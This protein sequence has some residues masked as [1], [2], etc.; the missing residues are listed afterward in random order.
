MSGGDFMN[1]SKWIMGGLVVVST[2]AV[3]LPAFAAE[4]GESG[5]SSEGTAKPKSGAKTKGGADVKFDTLKGDTCKSNFDRIEKPL[6]K[7]ISAASKG[8]EKACA[9]PNKSKKKDVGT[10]LCSVFSKDGKI[11]KGVKKAITDGQALMKKAGL[12]K[13]TESY[14]GATKIGPRFISFTHESKGILMAPLFDRSFI[15]ER[16]LEGDLLVVRIV[17]GK[18]AKSSKKTK[19]P[20]KTT[21][22]N[23]EKKPA[24]K[25]AKKTA[26]VQVKLCAFDSMDDKDNGCKC[27]TKTLRSKTAFRVK[28]VQGKFVQV[29]LDGKGFGAVPYT[30]R[31]GPKKVADDDG[32]KPEV[33]AEGEKEAAKIE[34]GKDVAP[35]AEEPATP[36][37]AAAADADGDDDDDDDAATPAAPAEEAPATTETAPAQ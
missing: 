21:D 12:K 2:S 37:A 14:K 27:V 16:P 28:G 17:T 11:N 4:A 35:V 5:E 36:A 22:K 20:T 7:A 32:G 24:K 19:A 10:F 31:V 3:A 30:L 13:V 18:K 6:R 15:S 9:G 29:V 25:P 26:S 23:A 33:A 8:I 1:L 34:E